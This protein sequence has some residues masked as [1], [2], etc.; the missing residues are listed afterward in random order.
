MATWQQLRQYID[1]TYKY[2]ELENGRLKLTFNMGDGGRQQVAILSIHR[3]RD[4]AEEWV[5]IESPVG[6]MDQINLVAALREAGTLVCGALAQDSFGAGLLV[7]RHTLPLQ[8]M[9]LNEFERPLDLVLTSGDELER[10]LTG[11]DL[12]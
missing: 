7:F 4:G 2:T 10:A 11:Q 1:E 12:F 9:D 6:P 5:L 8:N 3:L